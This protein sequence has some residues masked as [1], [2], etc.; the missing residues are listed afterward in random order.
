VVST[1]APR[2]LQQTEGGAKD[3]RNTTVLRGD[4]HANHGASGVQR[5]CMQGRPNLE[6]H[7]RAL[8]CRL[9]GG[10][11]S[12]PSACP[13]DCP[14]ARARRG[15]MGEA[16]VPAEPAKAGQ[17]PRLPAPH[18][19]TGRPGDPQGP[20]A[21][22]PPSTLGLTW[23]IRDRATHVALRRSGRRVRRGPVTVTWVPGNPDQPPR[24]AY[25]VGRR[26]GNAVARNRLR[27]RLRAAT[28]ELGGALAPGAYLVGAAREAAALTYGEL[29][30][31]LWEA[32]T[33][34]ERRA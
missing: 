22:G 1:L 20:P 11:S 28:R 14:A 25:A 21:Q 13:A 32:V 6:P 31:K 9:E 27:R 4:R 19:D 15:V 3:A 30:E 8:L 26:A 24:V 5:A 10:S 2:P 34:L 7:V 29:K 17:E 16:D 33:A 18:V 12:L 23:R